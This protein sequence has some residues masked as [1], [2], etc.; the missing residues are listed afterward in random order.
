MDHMV[1]GSMTSLDDPYLYHKYPV[2]L[3]I[4][5]LSADKST[6]EFGFLHHLLNGKKVLGY[7]AKNLFMVKMKSILGTKH[8]EN[9]LVYQPINAF[10]S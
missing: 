2:V 10:W 4:L 3:P 8:F 6:Y 7:L 5:F 1:F 9:Y